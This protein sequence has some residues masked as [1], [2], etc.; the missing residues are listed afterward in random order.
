[1]TD[2]DAVGNAG[3]PT[4]GLDDWLGAAGFVDVGGALSDL[5][6]DHDLDDPWADA[7]VVPPRLTS[8][9]RSFLVGAA[10]DSSG[11]VT[12]EDV[13]AADAEIIAIPDDP[14]DVEPFD[15]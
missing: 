2:N 12:S 11:V 4:S 7:M 13:D 14:D 1:M 15:R 3:Q 8:A 5:V 10:V 9:Q 6:D